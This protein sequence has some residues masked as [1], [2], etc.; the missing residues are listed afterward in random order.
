M[1]RCNTEAT[2]L[3]LAEIATRI[4]PGAHAVLLIDRAALAAC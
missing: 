4:A 1:P 2:N 3:H